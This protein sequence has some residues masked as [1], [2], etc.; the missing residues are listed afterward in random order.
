MTGW[1]GH[2]RAN[3]LDSANH[4]ALI[5]IP[6]NDGIP[7]IYECGGIFRTVQAKASFT[8]GRIG[9]VAG[10]AV[11]GENRAHILVVL[12]LGR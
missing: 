11:L 7:A 1:R 12:Q 2:E 8:C 10:E 9:T 5:R 6:S 4:L 3:S